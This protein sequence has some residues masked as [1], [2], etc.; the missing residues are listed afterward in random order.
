MLGQSWL[1]E[2]LGEQPD[3]AGNQASISSVVEGFLHNDA[4]FSQKDVAT[5]VNTALQN[6]AEE[7]WRAFG[8]G[9]AAVGEWTRRVE[10]ARSGVDRDSDD[11]ARQ[12][13]DTLMRS[14]SETYNSGRT[15][16]AR[17]VRAAQ[18][19]KQVTL[20]SETYSWLLRL[21]SD[22]RLS[23]ELG[24]DF[25]I[26]DAASSGAFPEPPK[27]A[28]PVDFSRQAGAPMP[29][30]ADHS[31]RAKDARGMD[32]ARSRAATVAALG[33]YHPAGDPTAPKISGAE[34]EVA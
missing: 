7:L 32:R 27:T 30:E 14:L 16:F 18:M 22:G 13:R 6:E 26:D 10:Q 23:E 3:P 17:A 15:A 2:A 9:M 28:T 29:T 21:N 34:P 12:K 33:Q 24:A 19:T 20:S 8:E 31:A 1:K 11:G 4:Q 25:G 5:Y